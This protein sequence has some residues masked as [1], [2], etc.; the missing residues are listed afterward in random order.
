MRVRYSSI[1][2][3]ES[4]SVIRLFWD[5]FLRSV[6]YFLLIRISIYEDF[7]MKDILSCR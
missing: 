4:D 1:I 2:V 6:I 5:E 3:E 7:Y